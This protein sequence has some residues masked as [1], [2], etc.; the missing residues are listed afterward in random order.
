MAKKGCDGVKGGRVWSKM[1][2]SQI[3]LDAKMLSNLNFVIC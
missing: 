3:A 1:K 2:G